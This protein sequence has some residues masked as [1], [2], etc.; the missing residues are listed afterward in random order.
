MNCMVTPPDVSCPG[1]GECC[2]RLLSLSPVGL[3][4]YPY[5]HAR[6][7]LLGPRHRLSLLQCMQRAEMR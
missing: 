4:G 7:H 3:P 1:V 6:M 5:M 2:M